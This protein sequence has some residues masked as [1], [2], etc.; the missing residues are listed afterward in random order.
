MATS[1]YAFTTLLFRIC[2]GA[3]YASVFLLLSTG[4]F[5]NG[6]FLDSGATLNTLTA[7]TASGPMRRSSRK[8]CAGPAYGPGI[9]GSPCT[10]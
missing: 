5:M 10:T 4:V 1:R 6:F 3:V 9:A 8:K 7:T 2:F